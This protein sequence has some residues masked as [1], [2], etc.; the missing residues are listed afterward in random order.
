MIRH[1]RLTLADEELDELHILKRRLGRERGRRI[2]LDELLHE[3]VA[4]LLR[5]HGREAATEPTAVAR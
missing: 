5:Y 1:A 2:N 3:A 4:M